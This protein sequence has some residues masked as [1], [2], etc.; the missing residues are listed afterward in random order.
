MQVTLPPAFI[1]LEVILPASART[2]A[3]EASSP[4]R[5]RRHPH[6]VSATSTPAAAT[7]SSTAEQASKYRAFMPVVEDLEGLG[8]CTSSPS[9][10]L[11]AREA[12][13]ELVLARR[14]ADHRGELAHEEDHLVPQVLELTHLRH[15]HGVA[16]VE[17]G[18][19]R[20]EAR[21]DA[22][23]PPV[24]SAFLSRASSSAR[25][26]TSTAPRVRTAIC[27]SRW[28]SC[29]SRYQRP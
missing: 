5:T 8:R 22:K 9:L 3:A 19:R 7:S 15:Q 20:I 6:Q 16:D 26:W 10:H 17:I 24:A 28:V 27:S 2:A 23:G 25:T 11:F 4:R 29:A 1:Y 14:I 18:A 13:A 12:R 21:L